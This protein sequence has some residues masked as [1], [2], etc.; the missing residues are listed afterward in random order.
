MGLN[1][2]LLVADTELSDDTLSE[3]GVQPTGGTLQAED[4]LLRSEHPS[5]CVV[6]GSGR[7][8]IVDGSDALAEVVDAVDSEPAG[9]LS[10]AGTVHVAC[11]VDT[12][13]FADYRIFRE[14]RLIRRLTSEEGEVTADE[15]E[16]VGDESAFVFVADDGESTEVDGEMLIQSLPHVA[17]LDASVDVFSLSGKE[18]QRAGAVVGDGPAQPGA[19]DPAPTGA[20]QPEKRKGFFGR[21][22]GR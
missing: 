10:L 19:G 15:G 11:V 20:T 3:L 6:R 18:Y 4:I 7:T 8:V 16:P 1:T 12:V 5:A 9:V 17:G 13:G 14:G 22:F 21:I 2:A